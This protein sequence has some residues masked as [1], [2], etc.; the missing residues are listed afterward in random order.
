[1]IRGLLQKISLT[2]LRNLTPQEQ[3]IYF[4]GAAAVLLI[5]ASLVIVP[6]FVVYYKLNRTVVGK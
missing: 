1:M 6:I 3:L 2:R 5:L 4:G